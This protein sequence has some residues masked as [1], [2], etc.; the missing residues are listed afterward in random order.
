MKFQP[1]IDIYQNPEEACKGLQ[2]GQWVSSGTPDADRSNC[3]VF[4]GVKPSGSIVVAWN[5][6]AR[7]RPSKKAYRRALMD[8]AKNTTSKGY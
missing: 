7:Q 5:G 3:G 6:N 2:P 1:T 8:Y 4:C